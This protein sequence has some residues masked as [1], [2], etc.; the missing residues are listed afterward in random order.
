MFFKSYLYYVWKRILS[1]LLTLKK[2]N[3]SNFQVYY[4]VY[5]HN[6]INII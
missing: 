6:N 5:K 4:F 2:Y 3:N 1:E